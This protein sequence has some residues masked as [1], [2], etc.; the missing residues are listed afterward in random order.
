MSSSSAEVFF[1]RLETALAEL[2][3]RS[4]RF[5]QRILFGPIF[6]HS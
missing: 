6:T 3:S 4:H 1:D 5:T 2:C